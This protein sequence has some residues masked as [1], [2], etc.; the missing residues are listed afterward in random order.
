M[1]DKTAEHVNTSVMLI[2]TTTQHYPI[3]VSKLLVQ[4]GA[5]V[6]RFDVL[7]KYTYT[8][9]VT[10]GDKYGEEREVLRTFP[11]EFKSET[12]GRLEQWHIKAGE[13]LTRPG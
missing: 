12:E 1:H 7:F 6:S 2:R 8:S 9:L 10:E 13:V 11:E 5:E 3:T 4:S